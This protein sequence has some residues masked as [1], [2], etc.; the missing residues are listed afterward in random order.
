[1]RGEVIVNPFCAPASEFPNDNPLLH[2]GAVFLPLTPTGRARAILRAESAPDSAPRV[3]APAPEPVIESGVQPRLEEVEPVSDGFHE[4]A[5]LLERV[6]VE[7]GAADSAGVLTTLLS[8]GTIDASA[9]PPG[10]AHALVDHGIV[11]SGESG[12]IPSESFA[13][14]AGAWRAVL[15]GQSDDLS[16]C[17]ATLDNWCAELVSI[18]CKTPGRAPEIRRELRRFGVAAFGLL[19]AA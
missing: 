6:T 3:E 16:A 19:A 4:L 11:V 13:R 14:T 17:E 10:T 9:L 15:S 7:H 18:L 2:C 1:M 12:L 5:Q 8:G